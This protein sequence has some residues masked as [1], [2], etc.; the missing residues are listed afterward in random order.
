MGAA[1]RR[2]PAA[3]RAVSPAPVRQSLPTIQRGARSTPTAITEQKPAS[4]LKSRLEESDDDD[5]ED[6][7]NVRFEES[8]REISQW[9]WEPEK[10]PRRCGAVPAGSDFSGEESSEA[11][12]RPLRRYDLGVLPED[13][14]DLTRKRLAKRRQIAPVLDRG[15]HATEPFCQGS[16]DEEARNL[17]L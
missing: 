17:E 5:F 11:E 6:V 14:L 9:T 15:P 16:S 4:W 7:E 13:S 8:L 3:S 12:D 2:H 10:A 1:E